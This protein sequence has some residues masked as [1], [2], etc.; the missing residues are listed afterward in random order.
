MSRTA[1]DVENKRLPSEEFAERDAVFGDGLLT[2][3]LGAEAASP[4]HQRQSTVE[5]PLSMAAPT[6]LHDRG[7]TV[8]FS[9]LM[10]LGGV[11]GLVGFARL[12]GD[13]G[14]ST[15]PIKQIHAA[16][17]VWVAS[18]GGEQDTQFGMDV[19]PPTWRLLMLKAPKGDGAWADIE[20]LRPMWWLEQKQVRA[21][22]TVDISVPECGIDGRAEVLSVSPCPDIGEVPDGYRVV[23]GRFV[24]H[25][26]RVIDLHVGGF[27]AR[28]GLTV[29]RY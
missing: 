7:W 19:D 6:A 27:L 16:E 22:G 21:G 5:T 9:L 8:F 17:V 14:P 15:K 20:L 10:V 25:H 3:L 2:D 24:H 11:L 26:A 1:V 12:S 29:E 4:Y 13:D 18:V 23:T 28:S